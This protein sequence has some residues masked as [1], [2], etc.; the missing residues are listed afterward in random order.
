M[1]NIK[2]IKVRETLNKL[3]GKILSLATVGTMLLSGQH[4]SA[5]GDN[6]KT[7]IDAMTTGDRISLDLTK[8]EFKQLIIEAENAVKNDGVNLLP[9]EIQT[10]YNS[11]SSLTGKEKEKQIV[12][13]TGLCDYILETGEAN[14]MSYPQAI[15]FETVCE[16]LVKNSDTTINEIGSNDEDEYLNAKDIYNQAKTNREL[17]KSKCI[18]ALETDLGYYDHCY[19]GEQD[20]NMPTGEKENNTAKK[21]L[22]VSSVLASSGI[23]LSALEGRKKEEKGKAYQKRR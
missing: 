6:V 13:L 22:L 11:L 18:I 23:L 14:I 19:L 21:A 9:F 4:V 7:L 2:N 15:Q 8:E 12:I 5:E 17:Q 20:Q 3:K 1:K 10:I 16:V